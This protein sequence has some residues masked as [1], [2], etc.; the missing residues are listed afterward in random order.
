[1]INKGLVIKVLH[2]M[3]SCG[4]AWADPLEEYIIKT[5]GNIIKQQFDL[6]WEEFEKVWS[7]EEYSLDKPT[8]EEIEKFLLAFSERIVIYDIQKE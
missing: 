1:M 8:E 5:N 3:F 2:K 4:Y 6:E 7:T